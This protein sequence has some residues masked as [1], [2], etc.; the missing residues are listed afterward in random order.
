MKEKNTRK[1]GRVVKELLGLLASRYEKNRTEEKAVLNRKGWVKKSMHGKFMATIKIYNSVTVKI[2]IHS[3]EKWWPFLCR[4]KGRRS[5][6]EIHS[7]EIF[8]PF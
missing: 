4:R 3:K 8:L 7:V 6:D 1:E 5:N 2:Q